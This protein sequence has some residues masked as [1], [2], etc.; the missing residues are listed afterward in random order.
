MINSENQ[1]ATKDN[2]KL[3]T[4]FIENKIKRKEVIKRVVNSEI[5]K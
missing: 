2:F 4:A 5:R 3:T 1:S